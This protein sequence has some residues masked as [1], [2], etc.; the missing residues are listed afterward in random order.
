VKRLNEKSP[1]ANHFSD[2]GRFPS[3]FWTDYL[4]NE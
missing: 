2:Q 4:K 1:C 3:P